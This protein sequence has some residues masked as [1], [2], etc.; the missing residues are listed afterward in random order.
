MCIYIYSIYISGYIY[1][2]SDTEAHMSVKG[3]RRAYC[4]PA[5][6]GRGLERGVAGGSG[7]G[8]AHDS[9][10]SISDRRAGEGELGHPAL[11]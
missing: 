8:A 11:C 9:A 5:A 7:R 2:Y 4:K 10:G 3:S 6:A 1:I